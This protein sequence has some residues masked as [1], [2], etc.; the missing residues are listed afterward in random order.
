MRI[1]IVV[2]AFNAA[3]WIGGAIASVIAQTHRDWM[4]VVVDD[5][6]TDGT[7]G[8]VEGFADARVRLVRQANAGVS[9]ARNRGVAELCRPD[10]APQPPPQRGGGVDNRG[11]GTDNASTSLPLPSLLPVPLGEGVGG[12]GRGDAL[13]FL[14]ADDWLAPNALFRLAAALEASP[15]AVA[16][17]GACAFVGSDATLLPQGGDILERLLV[18]NLF[19]N[20]GHLLLR[21]AI[22]QIAGGFLPGLAYGEDWEFCVRIALLGPF[23]ATRGP[24]PVLFVRQH[25]GGAYQQL[26][27]DPTAF[28]PCMDAIFGNPALLARF[29]PQRLA[30]IRR[31][32]DAEN[33]WIIGRELIRHGRNVEGRAWLRRSVSGAPTLKRAALLAAAH[34]LALLPIALRGPFRP[35]RLAS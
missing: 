12:R 22:V 17:S 29:G 6:S 19:A 14:D 32:S 33:H 30:A 16:A 23:A 4:L 15:D 11:G 24:N 35:Y 9:A 20:G 31:R 25:R 2:P 3:P 34:A 27:H 26:A 21:R 13:L 8:V 28:V 5:G 18:R 10:P 7:A 1:G